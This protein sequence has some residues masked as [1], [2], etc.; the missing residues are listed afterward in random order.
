MLGYRYF[1]TQDARLKDISG[2]F[3]SEFRNHSIMGG[4]RVGF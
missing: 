3:D 1:E 4:V 2:D